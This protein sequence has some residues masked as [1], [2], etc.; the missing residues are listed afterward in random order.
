MEKRKLRKLR[1]QSRRRN[2]QKRRSV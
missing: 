2:E 1:V